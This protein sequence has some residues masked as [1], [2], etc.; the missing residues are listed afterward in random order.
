MTETLKNTLY[1]ATQSR[2]VNFDEIGITNDLMFGTV[3]KNPEY[4]KELLQRILQIDIVEIGIVEP[5]KTI[6]TTLIGKGIRID[7]Y[8]KDSQ[9]NV[10][11]IE[12][13]STEETDLHL[14]TRYYHSEMDSYQI[15]AGQKYKNLKKSVVIFICTFDPFEDNR[16]I[17]TFATICKENKGIVLEDKRL[18]YF[19][20]IHGSRA[21]ISRKTVDLLDY[22][23]TGKP[24]DIYTKNI[25]DQVEIIRDDNEWRENYMTIEMK[26][27]QKYEDGLKHGRIEGEKIGRAEGEIGKEK[28]KYTQ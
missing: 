24:T 16:S 27:D 3:Y 19:V 12:M 26:M 1:E 9:G 5:Q 23:K 2:G 20:N 21:G 13:Q 8:A 28:V 14:R 7:I 11:D 18:T 6:K 17:Y 10:Y 22:F 15:R 4:C 25:Q